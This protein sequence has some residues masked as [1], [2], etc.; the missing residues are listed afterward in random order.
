MSCLSGE[1]MP[2]RAKAF[3]SLYL[4][5]W[6]RLMQAEAAEVNVWDSS[7]DSKRFKEDF[8]NIQRRPK[9]SRL[10]Q[11]KETRKP[12]CGLRK[13]GGDRGRENGRDMEHQEHEKDIREQKNRIKQKHPTTPTHPHTHTTRLL[14]THASL[15]LLHVYLSFLPALLLWPLLFAFG[16]LARRIRLRRRMDE[17]ADYLIDR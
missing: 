8:K 7:Q 6:W 12:S 17:D 9:G 2:S 11:P 14:L 3:L 5:I 13:R 16:L 4:F 10:S 1:Q 15:S